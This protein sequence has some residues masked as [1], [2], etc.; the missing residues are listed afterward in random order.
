[1]NL[2]FIVAIRSRFFLPIA[3]RRSSASAPEKP[4]IERGDLH[5]LLLVDDAAVGLLG[6]RPQARVGVAD[7]S[8]GPACPSRRRGCRPSRRAGRGRRARRGRRTRSARPCAAPRASPRTRTGR[9][10]SSRRRRASRR[11]SASSIGI[12]SMSIR[13]AARALDDVD[14]VLDHVEVAEAEEVHLQQP[15]LLDRPHRVLGH[16]LVLALGLAAAVAVAAG[17][18][19]CGPRPAAAARSPAAAGRRSPPRRRGS[20][21]CG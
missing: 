21:C 14:R 10:R 15:D 1:M 2:S 16:D 7:R 9:R 6:D 20:S 3:L 18:A 4:A 11:S 13:L 12:V 5:Q 17:R 19:R 8:R